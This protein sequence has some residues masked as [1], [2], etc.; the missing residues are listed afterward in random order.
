MLHLSELVLLMN[1]ELIASVQENIEVL[2]REA[3]NVFEVLEYLNLFTRKYRMFSPV[4]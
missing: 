4:F 3:R 2:E 1:C